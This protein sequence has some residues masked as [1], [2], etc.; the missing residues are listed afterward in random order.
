VTDRTRANEPCFVL[1]GHMLMVG[2][3]GRTELA[4]EAAL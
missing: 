4:A 3:L 2:D 1:T